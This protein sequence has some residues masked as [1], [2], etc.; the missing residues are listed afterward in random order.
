MIESVLTP[1]LRV[2]ST[3][4]PQ[5]KAAANGPADFR[6]GFVEEFLRSRELSENSKKAY[7]RAL[8]QFLVLM[9]VHQSYLQFVLPFGKET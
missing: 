6:W 1:K 8:K 7:T 3:E 5:A 4:K 2:I 9:V